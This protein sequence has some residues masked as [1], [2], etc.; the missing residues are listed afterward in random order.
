V[1]SRVLVGA[2][3]WLLGAASA[4]AGS[5]YAVAQLGQGLVAQHATRVSV[6]MVNAELAQDGATASA[7]GPDARPS[8]TTSLKALATSA[9][10]RSGGRHQ[11]AP[12][13]TSNP[14][15]LLSSV[16]GTTVATCSSAGAELLSWSPSPAQEFEVHRVVAGPSDVAS[17][18][19]M[20][21]SIGVIM[22]VR[23]DSL[24][25]PVPLDHEFKRNSWGN[26]HDE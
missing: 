13:V 15:K 5:L 22:N 26:H 11:T 19:F 1:G 7:T 21:S 3:A 6:A 14:G 17:V 16:G 20:N 2:S 9:M 25:V 23:C 4:T 12:P 8:P 18:T 10:H 24:G